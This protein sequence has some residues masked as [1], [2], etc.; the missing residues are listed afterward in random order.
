MEG[1][2]EA[3]TTAGVEIE[4]GRLVVEFES[5]PESKLE[6]KP[7]TELPSRKVPG[8]TG[9]ETTRRASRAAK[10]ASLSAA[11]W[12]RLTRAATCCLSVRCGRAKGTHVSLRSVDHERPVCQR[13]STGKE[14]DPHLER[15]P[16]VRT[17]VVL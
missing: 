4:V 17:V 14:G 11:I 10:R 9:A 7:R 5:G 12:K 6:L 3:S 15:L 13:I 1:M 8:L 2:L 16:V